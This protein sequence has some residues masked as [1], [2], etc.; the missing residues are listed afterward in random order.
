MENQ[1]NAKNFKASF[2]KI[3]RNFLST[4]AFTFS[5]LG[6]PVEMSKQSLLNY[7]E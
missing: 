5:V 1:L 2:R 3:V 7:R 4:C 6:S